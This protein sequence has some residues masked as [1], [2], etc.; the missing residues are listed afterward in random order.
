M[1]PLRR[2]ML[3]AMELRGYS[4]R[5][6]QAYIGAMV[7]L[8]RH[9]RRSPDE[10]SAEEVQQYLLHLHRERGLS[11]STINQAASAFKFFYG[12]VLG[13]AA[14]EA[15][16]PYARRP[17]RVSAVLTREEVARLLMCAPTPA[18]GVFLRL[19]YATG[20]RLGE[21]CRLRWRDLEMVADRRCVRV[22][23]G[24]GGKDRLVPLAVD[25]LA[26]MRGWRAQQMRRRQLMGEAVDGADAEA[27]WVFASARDVRQPLRHTMAQRW[28]HAAA[29][30]AGITKPGGPQVL[31][32]SYATHLLEAGVDLYT[33]QQWLGHQQVS[34][35]ARYLHLVRPD[36][37]VAQRGMSLALLQALPAAAPPARRPCEVGQ[38]LAA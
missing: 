14:V 9:S 36:A 3:D 7:G 22:V 31:R 6:V 8:A 34:T 30:A 25:A 37:T 4:R 28:Y 13:R 15:Q 19:A 2:R 23:Q 10:L 32:H 33:L 11:H 1:T 27:A 29:T 26:L 12:T 38:T 16:V 35:T 20:L 17:Q 24:K 5:T 21:L 18:A